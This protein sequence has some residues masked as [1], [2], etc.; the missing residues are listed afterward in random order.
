[1]YWRHVQDLTLAS[2]CA[3]ELY[4]Q[5]STTLYPCSF[6]SYPLPAQRSVF[7]RLRDRF[8]I[9]AWRILG[10]LLKLVSTPLLLKNL[11]QF[12]QEFSL[13]F[14][15]MPSVFSVKFFATDLPLQQVSQS[16]KI[17]CAECFDS[18]FTSSLKLFPG[19]H[20][21]YPNWGEHVTLHTINYSNIRVHSDIIFLVN[22]IGLVS[23]ALLAVSHKSCVGLFQSSDHWYIWFILFAQE[24]SI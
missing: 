3:A 16:L 21:R 1:M 9:T 15:Q 18:M 4:S 6:T 7:N 24:T 10:N 14:S 12:L 8:S 13:D 11:G 2:A 19:S 23:S 20:L 22:C 5:L 17:S